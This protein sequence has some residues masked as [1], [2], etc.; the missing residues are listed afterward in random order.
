LANAPALLAVAAALG[1]ALAAADAAARDAPSATPVAGPFAAPVTAPFATRAA[2]FL[3]AIAAADTA[4][5]MQIRADAVALVE[6]GAY[7]LADLRLWS[8]G[9]PDWAED[10]WEELKSALPREEGWDVWIEWYEDRLRGR[11][12]GEAYELAFAGVPERVWDNGPAAANAWI[13]EHLP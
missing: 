3:A 1:A 4:S 5:R 7:R 9:R 8:Q 11:S 13:R 12:R 6:V 10:A 2:P